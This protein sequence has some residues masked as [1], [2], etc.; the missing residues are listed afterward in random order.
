MK[1]GTT[2]DEPTNDFGS[3]VGGMISE[4]GKFLKVLGARRK[5]PL[6]KLIT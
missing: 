4:T 5:I 1:E 2:V 6:P 3:I